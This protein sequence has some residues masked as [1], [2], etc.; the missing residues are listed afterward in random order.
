MKGLVLLSSGIL[1]LHEE[2]GVGERVGCLSVEDRCV[3]TSDTVWRAVWFC[4]DSRG[5]LCLQC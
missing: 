1:V 3:F 4:P 5:L 2:A